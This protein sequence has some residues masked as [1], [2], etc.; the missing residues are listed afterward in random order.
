MSRSPRYHVLFYDY[1]PDAAQRRA[2]YREDHLALVR[3]FHEDGRLFM[4]GAVGDP[5]TGGLLV[6]AGEDPAP[7]EEFVAADPYVEGGIVTAHRIEPWTV[8]T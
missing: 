8:V 5:P 7:A 2:P 6:F 4:A 3:R 1:V